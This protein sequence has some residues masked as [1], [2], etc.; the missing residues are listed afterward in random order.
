M[1]AIICLG[2]GLEVMQLYVGRS[3]DAVDLATNCAGVMVGGLGFF[4]WRRRKAVAV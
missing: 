1:M 4:G 3:F 2:A